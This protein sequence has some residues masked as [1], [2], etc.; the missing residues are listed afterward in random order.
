MDSAYM[1]ACVATFCTTIVVLK[2]ME[3]VY[4]ERRNELISAAIE[5]HMNDF[6]IIFSQWIMI[7]YRLPVATNRP[8]C[9]YDTESIRESDS[10]EN[11]ESESSGS[12]SGSGS[13]SESEI[14]IEDDEDRDDNGCDISVQIV[15]GA[16]D[17]IILNK[18]D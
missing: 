12:G 11:S 13:E 3:Y 16:E 15:G 7:N 6:K 8:S 9:N 5:K 14:E 2:K 17:T 18:E 4:A 1:F 10:S